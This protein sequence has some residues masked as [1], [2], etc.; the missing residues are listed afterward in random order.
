[1]PDTPAAAE[2]IEEIKARDAARTQGAWRWFGNTKY[3]DI[4][5]ATVDRGRIYVMSFD[6]WGM[7]GAQ[8]FFQQKSERCLLEPAEAFV[9]YEVCPEVVGR[10]AGRK[11]PR[12]YREDF[13]SLDHPDAEFIA[14]ASEDVPFLLRA[15]AERDREIERLNDSV[16]KLT[17]RIDAIK[18]G[19]DDPES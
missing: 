18:G 7:Q 4:H 2:R 14:K 3:H 15:L 9:R 13:N 1:M 10:I 11:D 19:H 6:R 8:P 17:E 12:V 16:G 5:L